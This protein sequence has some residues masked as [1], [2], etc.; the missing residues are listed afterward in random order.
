MILNALCTNYINN[1]SLPPPPPQC[2]DALSNFPC[3]HT[4]SLRLIGK[5][6]HHQQLPHLQSPLQEEV[7]CPLTQPSLFKVKAFNIIEQSG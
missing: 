3:S 6:H 4:W 5:P 7:R 1:P 2:A